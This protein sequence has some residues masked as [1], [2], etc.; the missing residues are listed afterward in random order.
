MELVS[1]NPFRVVG[2]VANSKEK[3][4]QRQRAKLNALVNV[5]KPIRTDVDFPLL[6]DISRDEMSVKSAFS[7]IENLSQRLILSLFWFVSI[8]SPD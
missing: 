6:Y 8:G 2:L 7:S 5:G 1:K 4:I 3:D